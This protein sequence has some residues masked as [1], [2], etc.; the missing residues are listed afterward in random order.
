MEN[1]IAN[2]PQWIKSQT[3][4]TALSAIFTGV[5][6]GAIFFQIR[7]GIEQLRFDAWNKAQDLFT[8]K[9][10]IKD[11]TWLLAR[12]EKLDDVWLEEEKERAKQVC[13]KMDEFVRLA[14][15]LGGRKKF[16]D[17]WY[18]P[19]GKSW[20]VLKPIVIEERKKTGFPTKWDA[21]EVCGEEALKRF[22]P[23]RT[24]G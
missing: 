16:L 18:D 6:L 24:N 23:T 2:L 17:N 14:P 9:D 20:R 10:F 12:Q 22:P 8:D 4:W 21:F 5:G 7:G 19:V 1:L 3:F 15:F 13:R 11:R